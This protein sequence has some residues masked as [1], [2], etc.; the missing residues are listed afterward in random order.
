MSRQ[1]PRQSSRFVSLIVAFAAMT[2]L[3]APA[4]AQQP[5]STPASTDPASLPDQQLG[6]RFTVKAGGSTRHEKL[7]KVPT[8]QY[9]LDAFAGAVLRGVPTLTPPSE[10]IANMRVIDAVYR[11]AGMQPRQPTPL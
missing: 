8:Y 10:S 2:C 5:P 1:L 6:H 4:H 9:Q 11:A 3:L 7:P